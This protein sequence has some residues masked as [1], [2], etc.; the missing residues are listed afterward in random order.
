M[1]KFSALEYVRPSVETTEQQLQ[2]QIEVLKNAGS[3]E[4]ALGAF[5][6]R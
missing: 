6:K 4:E 1:N 5:M 2:Q 3:Y